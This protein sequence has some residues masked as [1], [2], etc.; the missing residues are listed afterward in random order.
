MSFDDA[1]DLLGKDVVAAIEAAMRDA[2]IAARKHGDPNRA[3]VA[4]DRVMAGLTAAMFMP[5]TDP[6]RALQRVDQY[7]TD[8][9]AIVAK[10][11]NPN[12]S[13]S[14]RLN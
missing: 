11:T 1:V 13:G 5:G 4:V 2:F 12:G 10:I 8:L 7:C 3:E 6:A 9:L 14:G